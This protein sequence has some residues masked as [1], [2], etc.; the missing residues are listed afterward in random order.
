[1]VLDE[2][3]T[4]FDVLAFLCSL[5]DKDA[6]RTCATQWINPTRNQIQ[7]IVDKY[8]DF[9]DIIQKSILNEYRLKISD[10]TYLNSELKQLQ[11]EKENKKHDIYRLAI[12]VEHRLEK[13]ST[14]QN[15]GV[16]YEIKALNA[17]EDLTGVAIYPC[18]HPQWNTEKSERNRERILNSYFQ[19]NIV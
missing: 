11:Q 12:E 3:S 16:L 8:K 13:Y 6:E 2:E 7:T 19:K 18:L 4:V 17:N 15:N 9:I 10:V 14:W 5:L 1:M